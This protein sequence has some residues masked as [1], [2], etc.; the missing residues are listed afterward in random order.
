MLND[1]NDIIG[2]VLVRNNVETVATSNGLYTDTIMRSQFNQAHVLAAARHKWPATEGRITTTFASTEES[3]YP[4]GWKSDGIRILM[5][6]GKVFQKVNI[7]DYQTYREKSPDGA[8]RI[9]SDFGRTVVINPNTGLSGTL[10]MR[11]QYMPAELDLTVADQKTVF[12][13]FHEEANEAI[14]EIMRSYGKKREKR[15]EEAKLVFQ[16]AMDMLDELWKKIKAEG[17]GYQTHDRGMFKRIDV[18]RGAFRED[19][20]RRDQFGL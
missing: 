17:Y 5:V 20:V 15:P 12:S 10:E 13:D 11:G 8:D 2:Q 1:A 7:I 6:G 18:V 9:F 16:G 19:T 4:E 3:P 14:V